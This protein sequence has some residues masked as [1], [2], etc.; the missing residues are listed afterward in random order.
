MHSFEIG[1]VPII[2]V[3]LLYRYND[4]ID[5]DTFIFDSNN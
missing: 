2:F 5:V 4:I 1:I 3:I